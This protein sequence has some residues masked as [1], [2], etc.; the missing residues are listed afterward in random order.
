[1]G[2]AHLKIN[3]EQNVTTKF[4]GEIRYAEYF[5]AGPFITPLPSAT[6]VL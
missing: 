2:M 3:P 1:M 5:T 6:E 4:L